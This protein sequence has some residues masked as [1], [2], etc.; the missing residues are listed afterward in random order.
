MI[1]QLVKALISRGFGGFNAGLAEFEVTSLSL[2]L[3]GKAA[4]R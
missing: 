1:Y 2:C 4:G 3:L